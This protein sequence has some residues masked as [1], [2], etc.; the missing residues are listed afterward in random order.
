MSISKYI[1][2]KI[3]ACVLI[4]IAL[5]LLLY[6]F[7]VHAEGELRIDPNSISGG[8]EKEGNVLAVNGFVV[9]TEESMEYTR[10]I[11]EKEETERQ[12]MVDALFSKE[13]S[14]DKGYD[15]AFNE[16]VT[17]AELFSDNI[18]IKNTTNATETAV[19]IA[20]DATEKKFYIIGTA[21]TMIMMSAIT[22]IWSKIR[23]ES[24][25]NNRAK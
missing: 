15:K 19:G 11:K 13:W 17:S 18:T 5:L 21:I 14:A 4:C 22:I 2:K 6:S 8:Y 1:A 24:N 7:D 25:R 10:A 20:K 9:F 16:L 12:E 23:N 3:I